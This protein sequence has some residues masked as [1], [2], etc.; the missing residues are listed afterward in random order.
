MSQSFGNN[1]LFFFYVLNVFKNFS[2]FLVKYFHPNVRN[3]Q[4]S[5]I[6][7]FIFPNFLL[8]KTIILEMHLFKI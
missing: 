6:L 2:W 7:V 5:E 1:I 8:H 3:K 4:P